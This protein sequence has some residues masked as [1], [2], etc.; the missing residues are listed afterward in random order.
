MIKL[1]TKKNQKNGGKFQASKEKWEG[2]KV[3][4]R[5]NKTFLYLTPT[6]FFIVA[7][8][9]VFT[10][11]LIVNNRVG[12]E[13]TQIYEPQ[14][15][16]AYEVTVTNISFNP[17]E[18]IH[19]MDI[20]LDS[21]AL[22]ADLFSYQLEVS[23]V[24]IADP[25]LSL[26]VEVV[27]VTSQFFIIYVRDLPDGFVAIRT[28]LTYSSGDIWSATTSIRTEETAAMIDENLEI[29]TDRLALM[30]YSL[31]NDIRVLN[32]KIAELEHEIHELEEEI[33][34]NLSHIQQLESDMSFQVGDQ[35]RTSQS[36]IEVFLNQNINLERNIEERE[37][38]IY[39]A[40]NNIE[41]I[42]ETI[43][44]L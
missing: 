37:N 36:R 33:A 3:Y 15:F 7:I 5:N 31:T 16:G 18:E 23:A 2:V 14:S 44:D 9:G 4:F 27:R 13:V 21:T 17:E 10:H 30:A 28:D 12:F 20:F 29:E 43:N 19:R 42:R 41:A 6:L 34:T 8:A 1:L 40:Q 32:L 35:L 24:A 38:E 39:E 11:G 25:S 26:D 22:N